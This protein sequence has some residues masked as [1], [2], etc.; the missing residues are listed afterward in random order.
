MYHVISELDLPWSCEWSS[1]LPDSVGSSPRSPGTKH[2][3]MLP[4]PLAGGP[5]TISPFTK[6]LTHLSRDVWS[7]TTAGQQQ[8]LP[9]SPS[10]RITKM[11]AEAWGRPIRPSWRAWT[12]FSGSDCRPPPEDSQTQP[13]PVGSALPKSSSPFSHLMSQ[14]TI[15]LKQNFSLPGP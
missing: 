6:R 5:E 1:L 9:P 11:K 10:K 14:L 3:M 4:W 15:D 12:Q 13:A 2:S 8:P 7:D